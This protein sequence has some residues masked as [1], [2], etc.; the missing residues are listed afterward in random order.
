MEIKTLKIELEEPSFSKSKRGQS[1]E[2]QLVEQQAML[3][4][5]RTE[6]ER[7]KREMEEV[8]RVIKASPLSSAKS[9]PVGYRRD[10]DQT[11]MEPALGPASAPVL[12]ASRGESEHSSDTTGS[13][14][15]QNV[16]DPV[17]ADMPDAAFS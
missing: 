11:D 16:A 1:I 5:L 9:S 10:K 12:S 15:P 14:P 8:K 17:D 7:L 3:E 6:N 2:I 13:T 4:K